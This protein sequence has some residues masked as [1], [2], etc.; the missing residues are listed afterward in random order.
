MLGWLIPFPWSSNPH[1]STRIRP[2]TESGNANPGQ[3]P[4]CRYI[5]DAHT[6]SPQFRRQVLFLLRGSS[7]LGPLEPRCSGA[8]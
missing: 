3:E 2:S 7:L 4:L 1:E 8:S 6:R 5:G